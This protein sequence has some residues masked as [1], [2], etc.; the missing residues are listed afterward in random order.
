MTDKLYLATRRDQKNR[1]MQIPTHL[2]TLILAFVICAFGYAGKAQFV[3]YNDHYAGPTTH[4]TPRLGMC[5]ARS[6]ARR[7]VRERSKILPTARSW[8]SPCR[9][10]IWARRRRAVVPMP[11]GQLQ[12]L[13]LPNLQQLSP[14]HELRGFRE[15][16][17]QPRHSNY[18]QS[19]RR[20]CLQRV[21][22]EPV[23]SVSWYGGSCEQLR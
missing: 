21:G 18:Q 13:P 19:S 6:A 4:S 9:S 5:T 16:W 10:R 17:R 2:R 14:D 1:F 20:P 11:V 23:L 3:A 22:Y 15:R 12:V 8:E 7:A